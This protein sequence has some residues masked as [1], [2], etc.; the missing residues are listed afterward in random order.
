MRFFVYSNCFNAISFSLTEERFISECRYENLVLVAGG[1]GITPFFAI[2]SDILHRKR[3]GKACLPSKVLVVWAIKN[4]DE[5][6]LLSAI[7]IPSICPFFSKKLN[8]EIHI[9]V[10]RQSEPR[11]VS[12][13]YIRLL[14]S[15]K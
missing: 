4:S 10:T 2:L 9:Y 7:D 5:L 1:I 6:S 11:L 8:L 14:V 12:L 13:T 3:D 15:A